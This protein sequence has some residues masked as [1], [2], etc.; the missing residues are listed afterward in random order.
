MRR[1]GWRICWN[2]LKPVR[3]ANGVTVTSA[4]RESIPNGLLAGFSK[5]T[6]SRFTSTSAAIVCRWRW[7]ACQP[8]RIRRAVA[9]QVGFDSLSGFRDAFQKWFGILPGQVS[10]GH[11]TGRGCR[12]ALAVNRILTPLGPMVIAASE[13]FIYLLEFSDCPTLRTGLGQLSRLASCRFCPGRNS[14]ITEATRSWASILRE[15]GRDSS[16]LCK[17]RDPIFKN[18]FG[19]S[20]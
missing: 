5:T 1:T 11:A 14:L 4:I 20:C 2:G 16:C 10:Q 8:A 19:C 3:R 6:V 17:F 9:G 13:Q 18:G 7:P 12:L 15:P